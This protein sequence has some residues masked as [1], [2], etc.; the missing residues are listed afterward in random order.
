MVCVIPTYEANDTIIKVAIEASKYCEK[1]I[2]V[3]DACPQESGQ[4]VK[5]LHNDILLIEREINGGVGAAT[6]TGIR[7]ALELGAEIIVKLDSDGQMR[8]SLIP[9][10]IYPLE[11]K[12]VD[13]RKGTRFDS[14]ED[15]EG[16]PKIRLIGNSALSLVN[17]FSS[18]YWSLNDPTNGF[19][20]MTNAVAKNLSLDKI[21]DDYFFE[22]DLLFRLRLIGAKISQLRMKSFY[23]GE[24]SNLRPSKLLFPFAIKHVRNQ[25]KRFAYMY[26][27]REWNLGTLYFLASLLS[28][29]V[30]AIASWFAILQSQVSGVGTGTAVLASLGFI[31]WVQF[32]TQFFSVD[33][34]SEP[35]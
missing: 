11:N 17:K 28:L 26:L 15:L 9:E 5:G 7:R 16:M 18:G 27:V 20:A 8:P 3:D 2:V 33:V 35:K 12:E 34:S 19:L 6:K 1:V 32:T 21:S 10:L 31:L 29:I 22:S 14:P 13:F 4:K 30:A 24:K 23:S 25:M